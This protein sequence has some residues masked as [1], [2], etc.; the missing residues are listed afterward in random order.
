MDLPPSRCVLFDLTPRQVAAIAGEELPPRYRA[1]LARYRYGP[2]VFKVDWTLDG[3]VPWKNPDARARRRVHLGGTLE[4]IA[5]AEAEVGEGRHPERPFVLFAQQS[6]FDPT[7][8]P[9]GKHTGW[10]YCHV[11]NGS[12]VDMTARI[13]AQVERFAPGFH[14][15]V[16]GRHVSGTADLERRNA[17]IVGGDIGG[18]ANE[19]AAGPVPSGRPARSLFHAQRAAL[20]LLELDSAGRR[21]CTGCAASTRRA[22]PCDG[23]SAG[24]EAHSSR[25]RRRLGGSD[26]PHARRRVALPGDASTVILTIVPVKALSPSR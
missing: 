21:G 13:E 3:P 25:P 2:G 19:P 15:L 16:R 5:S 9:A 7:R 11:P 6:L 20:P 26:G 1:A 4:E 17:N 8:A 23:C 18:G 10:A 22:R 12:T 14:D 24:V